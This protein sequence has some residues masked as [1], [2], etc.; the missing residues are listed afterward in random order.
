MEEITGMQEAIGPLHLTGVITEHPAIGDAAITE[1]YGY[2]AGGEDINQ[3][4][5]P[6]SE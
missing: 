1:R 6:Q 5:L 3:S 4:S 2:K